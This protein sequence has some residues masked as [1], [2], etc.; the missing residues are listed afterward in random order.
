MKPFLDPLL[1]K[2]KQPKILVVG[3]GNSKLSECLY[4]QGYKLITNIDYSK[5]CIDQMQVA[6]SE[7]Y[8]EM[9]F[10]EMNS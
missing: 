1:S 10:V 4:N 8:D 2:Y 3:C 6:Y 7:G 5:T 9:K